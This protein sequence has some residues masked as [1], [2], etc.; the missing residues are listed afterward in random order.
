MGAG[1]GAGAPSKLAASSALTTTGA[2]AGAGA[3]ADAAKPSLKDES[4]YWRRLQ[5]VIPP[6]TVRV[7]KALEKGM[8]SYNAILTERSDL[9]KEVGALRQQNEELNNVLSQY[10]TA[11]VNDELIVPPTQTIRLDD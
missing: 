9:V 5:D 11:Q 6:R 10:L 2:G 1:A 4:E 3:G 7:W 8:E